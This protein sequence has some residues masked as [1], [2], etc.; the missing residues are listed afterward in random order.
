MDRNLEFVKMALECAP[1]AKAENRGLLD[2]IGERYGKD[3][4]KLYMEYAGMIY[5]ALRFKA[6]AQAQA[7]SL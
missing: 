5:D 1:I 2:V 3:G 6:R 4:L 7:Q